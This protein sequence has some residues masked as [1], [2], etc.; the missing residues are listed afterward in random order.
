MLKLNHKVEG[1]VYM[2]KVSVENKKTIIPTYVPKPAHD[3]PMFF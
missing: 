1:V 2:K 3:L